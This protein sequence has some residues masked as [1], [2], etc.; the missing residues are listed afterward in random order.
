MRCSMGL[1]LCAALCACSA[2]RRHVGSGTGLAGPHLS[3]T[4][5]NHMPEVDSGAL[6]SDTLHV[7]DDDGTDLI[8]MK[9]VRDENGE[10]M[11]SDVIAPTVVVATFRNVA[12]RQGMVDLRFDI[13]VPE[14]LTASKWQLRLT[15]KMYMLGE[16]S[17]LESLYITG[18]RY[19]AS[20]LRGYERY[21]RFVESIVQDSALF[22]RMHDLETFLKRNLP[23]LYAFRNDTARVSEQQWTSAFGVSGNEAVK[24][25]TDQLKLRHNNR[26]RERKDAMFRRYVK[27][28][29]VT[30]SIRLDTVLVADSGELVYSYVQ[31]V[32]TRPG[33]RKV[34]ISL[35]GSIYDEDR[36]L[37]EIP[38]EEKLT[39]YVSSISSFA[40]TTRHYLKR[41]IERKVSA[42]TSCYIEFA[43]GRAEVDETLGHNTEE[44]GRIKSNIREI[45]ENELFDLDS[46]VITAY[47]SPEG[48]LRSNRSLALKRSR[49]A[50]DFFSAY[51]KA[52]RD[53]LFGVCGDLPEVDFLAR[54]GGENWNM[55]THLVLTDSLIQASDKE[56]YASRM[57]VADADA[58]ENSLK[59]LSC[60]PYLRRSL[61]PRLRVVRFDFHLHRKGMLK[62]TVHT[63][64]LDSAYMAGVQALCAHEYEAALKYLAPYHDYNTAVAFVSLDRNHSAMEILAKLPPS[65]RTDYLKAILFA[66][67]GDDRK[68]V[69]HYLSACEADRSYVFRGS[70]DPEI[71]ALVHKYNLNIFQN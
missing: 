59:G 29:I 4:E 1:F 28:P 55:L 35:N 15:P 57:D 13:R 65:A 33:L 61:Y 25:Y 60:Y 42:N 71:S 34:E 64:I 30:D 24:H 5:E 19:R 58:R 48:S 16:E 18:K 51:T 56:F 14:E 40:D 50:S 37:F 44:M 39:F 41:I 11:A 7:K 22:I 43:Q 10:M 68:G 27:A 46:V 53:T 26:K 23:E 66:R 9:A 62:D 12:E 17:T 21:A 67:M 2:V 52:V 47:A 20:Q 70:L 45:V 36:K 8:I 49:A 63:T 31:T 3:L 69:R 32:R 6:L 38:A 54:E